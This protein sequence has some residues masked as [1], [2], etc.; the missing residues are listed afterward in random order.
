MMEQSQL[1][2][3]IIGAGPIG[4]AAAAQA[5][6]RGLRAL[7][8]EAGPSVGTALW[9]WGHVRV[10]SPWRYLIDEA[11][12]Q[13]LMAQD[14]PEPDLDALPLGREIVK[15]YLEPLSQLP[16]IAPLLHVNATVTS[17]SRSGL[18]KMSDAN[19]ASTPFAVRYRDGTGS[20]R[21][22]LARAVLDASGTWNSSN[23][24]G[25]DG[26]PVPGEEMA[27]D[28]IAYG[29]PDVV[30]AERH[31]YAG[32]HVLVVG[33]GHSAI[34]A[35]LALLELKGQEPGTTISWG[36]RRNNLDKLFGGGL[37]D[38]LP[39]R[40]ALGLA[41][42]QAI[43]QGAIRL[44][45]PLSIQAINR[46]ADALA[47]DALVGDKP[48]TLPVD[49]I[50]VAT[51]F[52]PDLGML[53]EV[54]LDLDP[55]VEAP[56]RLAPMIDPNLHS[57]GSVPPHG[58]EELSQPDTGFYIVGSKAYG[59]APTFLMATGYEQVRSVVAELAGDSKAAREVHLVL[60]ETGVCSTTSAAAGKGTSQSGCCGGPAPAEANA[61]CV[62][63]A[64]AKEQGR[65]GC[66][67]SS[68]KPERQTEAAE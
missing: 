44:L 34:Q 45:T 52:R 50:I 32:R 28:R 59:R 11:A 36:L 60:P 64:V 57:C 4:L 10:F 37:N 54:R 41:A 17:I 55:A 68:E 56:R 23:P 20:E 2:I 18:D 27:R 47:V 19:R 51:G 49:R 63:D 58:V 12:R 35:V 14:W 29:M 40:G 24:M 8:L 48:E 31:A 15:D 7:V 62:A 5:A 65:P 25:I 1:P 66:G 26:L 3:V 22:L 42:K 53:R 61:C 46:Q 38:Q 16:E 21:H 39:A 13:L 43:E 9:A 67:C 30:H 33:S 6:R